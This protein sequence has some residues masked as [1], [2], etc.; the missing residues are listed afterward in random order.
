MSLSTIRSIASAI[1]ALMPLGA[2]AQM[3]EAAAPETQLLKPA[4]RDQLLAPIALC[5][6]TLLAEVLM[7]SAYPLDIVQAERWIQANKNLTGDQ[8]K[9]EVAK[10]PGDESVKSLA[11]ARSVHEMT[12]AKLDWIRA[13]A[14]F[15][16]RFKTTTDCGTQ[17]GDRRS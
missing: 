15:Q 2:N 8:L 10:Q 1:M 5:P 12:A 17:R 4:E 9:P 3:P 11:V 7:A 14:K 6:D 16:L 13:A